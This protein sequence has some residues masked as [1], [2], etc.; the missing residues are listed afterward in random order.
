MFLHV[1]W[2]LLLH[3]SF[4]FR[5]L[6]SFSSLLNPTPALGTLPIEFALDVRCDPEFSGVLEAIH[7]T[8]EV[9]GELG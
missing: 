2:S 8:G 3:S 1:Y 9:F 6:A 4:V 5:S 7:L